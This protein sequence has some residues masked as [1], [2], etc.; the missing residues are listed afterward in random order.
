MMKVATLLFTYNRSYHTKQV[1][2]SL[3]QSTIL[4]Q[5]LFVFQDGIRRN[6]DADEW[7]KVNSLIS[8]IDWCDKEIVVSECNR[9]LSAAILSGIEY[10]FR[11][12][13]AIIVLEDDCVPTANFISFMYQCFEKY[14]DNKKV[15]SISGYSWPILLEKDQYDAYGCGR[16]S[17][18][19][20]G[21]W[22]DRWDIYEKDYEL[23]K[24]MKREE[25][26]SKS[27]AMW[28]WDLEDT[29]IGNVKGESD[30]WAVFWAAKVIENE[31]ICINPYD[32]LI[33]NIG[34][35]G[36]GVHCG[37]TNR[38]QVEIPNDL[39]EDFKLPNDICILG[40]TKK[41]FVSLCGSYTAVNYEDELKEKILVYGAGNF[42]LKN[43]KEINEKYNIG[44]F[45]DKRKHGWLEGKK[46]ISLKEVGQYTYDRILIMVWDI[47]ECANII[48]EL[49][50]LEISQEKI[51]SGHNLFGKY[52]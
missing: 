30:S 5:K 51:L 49:M 40:E 19:G 38:F 13:D 18:W 4:P 39:I 45:I 11:E 25:A 23:I 46:I 21:T 42:Y 16:I 17:S 48:K 7:K 9:G 8:Q 29:L 2:D 31:G 37:K 22:K 27:L 52:G 36:L 33:Q 10:V 20:W 1:I 34:H 3:K 41:A 26:S 15:Y 6:E 14:Q 12:Y 24:K 43:E 32:S 44:A 50:D 47:Q 28:G 35:D